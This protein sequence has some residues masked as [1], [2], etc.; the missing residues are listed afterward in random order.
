[1]IY[2]AKGRINIIMH[3]FATLDKALA[4]AFLAASL[5]LYKNIYLCFDDF[6]G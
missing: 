5:N 2:Q 4:R 1:M 3:F 6:L